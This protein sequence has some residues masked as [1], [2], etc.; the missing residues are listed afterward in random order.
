MTG[1]GVS[2]VLITRYKQVDVVT[3]YRELIN[4]GG[5]YPRDLFNEWNANKEHP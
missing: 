4:C 1:A 3:F 5:K 2:P